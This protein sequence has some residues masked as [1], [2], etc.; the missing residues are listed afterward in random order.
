MA[1]W[2]VS[3]TRSDLLAPFA[4]GRFSGQYENDEARRSAAHARYS[5]RF[6][7]FDGHAATR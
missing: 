1:D 4:A 6:Q 5:K 7:L 2:I 3:G